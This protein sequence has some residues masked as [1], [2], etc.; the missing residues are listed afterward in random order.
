LVL[1]NVVF[2]YLILRL[3]IGGA[4]ARARLIDR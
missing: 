1:L 3:P 2:R 4:A